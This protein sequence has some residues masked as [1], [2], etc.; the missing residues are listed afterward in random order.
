MQWLVI[1]FSG[2]A[3]LASIAAPCVLFAG[4]LP[5]YIFYGSNRHEAPR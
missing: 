5:R 3:K 4:V 2:Q 1:L